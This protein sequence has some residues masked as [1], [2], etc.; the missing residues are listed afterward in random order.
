M[1]LPVEN[2]AK[3][4]SKI[5]HHDPMIEVSETICNNSIVNEI[6]ILIEEDLLKRSNPDD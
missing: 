1:N 3:R 4:I 6:G 2:T 5:Y